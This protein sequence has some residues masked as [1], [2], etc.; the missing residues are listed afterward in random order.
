MC[1]G[2]GETL[3]DVGAIYPMIYTICGSV[4]TTCRYYKPQAPGKGGSTI[5]VAPRIT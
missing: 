4:Q 1:I 2:C 3:A 5:D